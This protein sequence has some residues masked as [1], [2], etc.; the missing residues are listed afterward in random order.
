MT[1]AT[2]ITRRD[3]KRKL[4]S[5]QTVV[6]TRYVL[7]FRDPSTGKRR[8]LF[9]RSQREAI[10]KRDNL[11][12]AIATN[13]YAARRSFLTVGQAIEHWLQDRTGAVRPSTMKTYRMV[14]SNLVIGPVLVGTPAQRK[15]YRE[16]GIRPERANFVEGLGPKRVSDLATAD[17][18]RWHRELVAQVGGR[19]AAMA[20]TFLRA[21]LALAAEDYGIRPPPMPTKLGRGRPRTKRTLLTPQQVGVLLQ[22]GRQ[23]PRGIYYCWPFLVG[24]RPSEQL[25]LLWEDVDL[26]RNV[27]HIRRVLERNGQLTEMMSRDDFIYDSI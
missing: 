6:H 12:A 8:Q 3:R 9:C 1:I 13:T 19:S 18:R 14:A 20:R 11:L 2:S 7:N 23:N 15:L 16:A 26:D 22:A 10:A 24:T 4:L 5:G 21:A 27:V 25:G 17:I